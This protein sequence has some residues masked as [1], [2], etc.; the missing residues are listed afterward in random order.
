MAFHPRPPPLEHYEPQGRFDYCSAI[1]DGKQYTYGGHCGAGGC[2]TLTAVYRFDPTNEV[3]QETPTSGEPPPG[4]RGACCCTIGL[5]L[6]HFGGYDGSKF[7]NTIHCL[8]TTDLSWSATTTTHM[9]GAPMCKA[10]SG[11][12]VYANNLVV[13]GGCGVLPELSDPDKYVPDPELGYE[14]LGW[15]NE[16]HC[17]HVDSS[18]LCYN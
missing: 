3:W 17:F 4:F 12:L 11:I 5:Q 2:P 10:D 15:T 9:Q 7:Y 16:V 8:N 18:E 6:F 14:G 1:V 13:S